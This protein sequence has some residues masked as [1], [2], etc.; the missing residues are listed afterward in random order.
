MDNILRFDHPDLGA[1]TIIDVNLDQMTHI[2]YT[3][4]GG[5]ITAAKI[6][7]SDGSVFNFIQPVM[8]RLIYNSIRPKGWTKD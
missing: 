3:S 6:T 7:T 8:A 4:S 5:E 2:I 1:G